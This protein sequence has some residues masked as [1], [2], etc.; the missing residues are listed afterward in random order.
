MR[1]TGRIISHMRD[2]IKRKTIL[3]LELSTLDEDL[4]PLEGF[5]LD[6]RAYKHNEKRSLNANG[7]YWAI[8]QQMAMKLNISNGRTHNMM[9]RRYGTL[10][11]YDG[12]LIEALFPYTDE[13]EERLLEDTERHWMP[14]SGLP[15]FR[16]GRWMRPYYM[17]KGSRDYNTAEMSKLIA[18]TV[19]E[20]KE[21]GIETLTPDEMRRMMEAYESAYQKHHT[22]QND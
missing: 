13:T 15:E 4:T 19:E 2:M 10:E 9:L 21:M 18:G 14:A 11:D 12:V 6:I 16:E 5:L 8:V 1:C 3:Q 17:I 22:D 20:A 7:L